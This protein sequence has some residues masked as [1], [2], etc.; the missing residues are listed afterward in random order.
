MSSLSPAALK[1]FNFGQSFINWVS[2]FYTSISSCVINDGFSTPLLEIQRRVR[3]G[4][5]L[6]PYL[7]I[8]APSLETQGQIVGARG[9]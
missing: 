1:P 8:A 3:K 6:S 7:F 2:V 4:D 9:K 5:P